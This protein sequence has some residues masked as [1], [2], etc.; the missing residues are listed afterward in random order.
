MNETA[1]DTVDTNED[2]STNLLWSKFHQSVNLYLHIPHS[3][4]CL[5][6]PCITLIIIRLIKNNNNSIDISFHLVKSKNYKHSHTHTQDNN[7]WEETL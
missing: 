2:D 6:Q 5:S 4:H 3:C 1:S 7:V